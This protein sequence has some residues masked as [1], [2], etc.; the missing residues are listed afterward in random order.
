[1]DVVVDISNRR[2]QRNFG[3]VMAG[4]LTVLSFLRWGFRGFAWVAMPTW[5]WAAAVG[6]LVVG[7][8]WPPALK[9]I[10]WLWMRLALALNWLMT[11]VFLCLAFYLLITPTRVLVKIFSED[12]LKRKWLP[13]SES[14]WEAPEEQP[15]DVARYRDQF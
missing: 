5:L 1:M 7:L 4:A 2:E 14:Y 3:L 9:P 11:R 12:P 8:L 13:S 10:F 15:T 6:F